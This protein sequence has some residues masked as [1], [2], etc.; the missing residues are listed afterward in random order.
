MYRL[1]GKLGS[2]TFG[3]VYRGRGPDGQAVAI[4][5]MKKD[6]G[7][8]DQEISAEVTAL[9]QMSHPHVIRMLHV[10]PA[11]QEFFDFGR[12]GADD[13]LYGH[14]M[15]MELAMTSLSREVARLFGL[16]PLPLVRRYAEHILTGLA[17]IH[18][19]GIIHRDLKPD[20]ILLRVDE[21]TGEMRA[22]LGDFGSS[23]HIGPVQSR[24]MTKDICTS[25]YRAP[26]LFLQSIQNYG[27]EIDMWSTGCVCGEMLLGQP[28]FPA[29]SERKQV[30][31]ITARLGPPTGQAKQMFRGL[32]GTE[33]RLVKG[34]I[35][36][37]ADKSF[38]KLTDI[39][40]ETKHFVDQFLC[41]LPGTRTTATSALKHVYLQRTASEKSDEEEEQHAA[42]P[43]QPPAKKRERQRTTVLQEAS[44]TMVPQETSATMPSLVAGFQERKCGCSG[45]CMQPGHRRNGC[46]QRVP[47]DIHFP[48]KRSRCE[49]C[50][51]VVVE[52]ERE[53]HDNHWLCQRHKKEFMEWTRPLQMA[54]YARGLVEARL[55]CDVLAFDV[56]WASIHGD[57]VWES[58]FGLIKEPLPTAHVLRYERERPSIIPAESRDVHYY[59]EALQHA[60]QHMDGVSTPEVWENLNDQG[61]TFI[62]IDC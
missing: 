56:A 30:Q 4:K 52:C 37:D 15:I 49:Q 7:G 11:T 16:M 36:H 10:Y 41:W 60:C 55:P 62:S 3:D 40:A 21:L 23:R 33:A 9:T 54:F 50:C 53:K 39:E 34:G 57:L 51:C 2:G 29:E 42:P 27:A 25:W 32:C 18:G 45:H 14:G 58:V 48:D 38:R 31:V 6:R 22:V 24:P 20:N 5:L 47:I 26:E 17:H 44:V 43:P 13:E 12:Q 59:A 28:L 1:A 46:Q 35:W 8:D 19:L 61:S